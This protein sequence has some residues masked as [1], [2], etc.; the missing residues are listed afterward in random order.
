MRTTLIIEHGL[1]LCS[2]D[3][4]FRLFPGLRFEPPLP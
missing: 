1:I 3:E 2:A 4:N